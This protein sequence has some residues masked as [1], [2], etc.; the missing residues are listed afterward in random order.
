M[1]M[2]VEGLSRTGVNMLIAYISFIKKHE[3]D[4]G[5]FSKKIDY[6]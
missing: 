2:S 1:I 5:E 4:F 6:N 3:H